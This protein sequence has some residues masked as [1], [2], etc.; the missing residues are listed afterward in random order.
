MQ[1]NFY[2]FL[3]KS[4]SF[5]FNNISPH[6]S[7]RSQKQIFLYNKNIVLDKINKIKLIHIFNNVLII[8]LNYLIKIFFIKSDYLINKILNI[9]NCLKKLISHI[10]NFF[11]D[12][13]FSQNIVK[14]DINFLV[15]YI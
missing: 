8:F 3:L 14:E 10:L 13:I 12:S 11:L 9:Y 1:L 5:T 15:F 7:L 2:N 6:S 4:L